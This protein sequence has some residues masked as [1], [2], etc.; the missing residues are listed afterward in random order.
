MRV[1]TIQQ[2]PEDAEESLGERFTRLTRSLL[3]A[4]TVGEALEHI[5]RATRWALPGSDLV[6]ITLRS[7]DGRFHTPIE[8][9]PVAGKLDQVQYDSGEG[10]C[11]D[12]AAP[13]SPG[14]VY[15][16]DLAHEPAWPVFGPAA[17]AHGYTAILSSSIHAD[18]RPP[19]LSGA[20]NVYARD[21]GVLRHEARDAALLLATHA[22]LALAGTEAVTQAAL[23]EESLRRGIQSRDV[24]G[25]AKGILMARREISADEAFDVLRRTSQDLN[26][27]LVDLARTLAAGHHRLDE[28]P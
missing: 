2:Q 1:V 15:S 13:G 16:A 14:Y 27:K 10:P 9:D 6:S 21:T 3:Q 18:K 19:Q 23:R 7:P 17:A 20:L 25:Q 12:A 26:V 24:I 22:S 5:V 8:T 4:D 11:L 28:Q